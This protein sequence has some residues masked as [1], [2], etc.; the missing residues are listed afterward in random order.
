MRKLGVA[1]LVLG[2]G[3]GSGCS[4]SDKGGGAVDPAAQ[5]FCLH[6]ANEICRLAY[7]CTDASA[8][9][10]AFH[11]RYGASIDTCWDGLDKRCESNQT[12][13]G[14]FGPSCGA[15]KKVNADFES[16]CTSTLESEA[17]EVWMLAPSPTV[18]EL[19]C[20]TSGIGP[21]IGGSGNAGGLGNGTGNAPN[22]GGG[23]GNAPGTG[24]SGT[25]SGSLTTAEGFCEAFNNVMCD[26]TF[27]CKPAEAAQNGTLADCKASIAPF[28]MSLD[29]FCPG[30]DATSAAG[31]VAAAK[32][33]TCTELEGDAPAVC[34]MTCPM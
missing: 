4:S 33:A 14:A 22:G 9:D 34:N 2:L 8:Q 6:W 5:D 27:E 18:C 17:C 7:L 30:Y 24:G 26:R 11:A 12:G 3:L 23:A 1:W 29:N 28:C 20:S 31:C 32:S 19:V 10:A 21:G 13:S 15:G 25:T 16:L